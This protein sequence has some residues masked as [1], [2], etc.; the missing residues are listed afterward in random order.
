[1]GDKLRPLSRASV[2]PSTTMMGIFQR[3]TDTLRGKVAAQ[4]EASQPRATAIS[5]NAKITFEG[6]HQSEV[7]NG[8]S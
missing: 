6:W 5:R 3:M 2:I 1:M 8:L 7:N 4:Q